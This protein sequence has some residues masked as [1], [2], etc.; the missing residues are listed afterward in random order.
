MV[1]NRTLQLR[2][3][4]ELPNKH[5]LQAQSQANKNDFEKWGAMLHACYNSK[6]WES[7]TQSKCCYVNHEKSPSHTYAEE[8]TKGTAKSS[9]P[10]IRKE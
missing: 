2:G 4:G 5:L 8:N 9:L 10:A 1:I 6:G 3:E 7:T